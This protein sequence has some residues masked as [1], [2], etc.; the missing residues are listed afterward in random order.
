MKNWEIDQDIARSWTTFHDFGFKDID[1]LSYRI[2]RSPAFRFKEDSHERFWAEGCFECGTQ[3]EAFKKKHPGCMR[4]LRE[5]YGFWDPELVQTINIKGEEFFDS[6]IKACGSWREKLSELAIQISSGYF[7]YLHR[8]K[9]SKDEKYVPWNGNDLVH[10]IKKRDLDLL[11]WAINEGCPVSG[12]AIDMAMYFTDVEMMECLMSKIPEGK[13]YEPALPMELYSHSN[14]N[15]TNFT[16]CL[17][18]LHKK[19]GVMSHTFYEN[20]VIQDNTS[21]LIH[22]FI[23]YGITDVANLI[24]IAY[25]FDA[26]DCIEYLGAHLRF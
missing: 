19:T 1:E 12:Q 21:L 13:L 11:K 4:H 6:V 8:M 7:K 24:R 23:N 17:R 5:S 20:A 2:M 15:F 26:R 3:M 9:T 10:I 25:K 18:I 14:P 16:E 22:M